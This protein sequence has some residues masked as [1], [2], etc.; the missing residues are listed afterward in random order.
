MPLAIFGNRLESTDINY[1]LEF[2]EYPRTSEEGVVAIYNVSGWDVSKAK[3][4][5]ALKNLQYS[6][7]YPGTQGLVNNCHFLGVECNKEYRTCNGIKFCKYLNDELKL[8]I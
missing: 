2:Q 8:L 6:I 3:A 4:T 7:G 5:F 1:H